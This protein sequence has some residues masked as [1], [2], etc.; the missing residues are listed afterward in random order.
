LNCQRI[1]ELMAGRAPDRLPWVPELNAGF[2]R[3][4]MGTARADA[5]VEFDQTD[6]KSGEEDYLGLEARCAEKIGADHLH[7]VQSVRVVRPNV[8]VET[9]EATGESLVHTPA[10]DLRQVKVYDEGSGT[11]Y[12]REHLVKG[13]EDF[14]AFRAM[15]ADEVYEADYENAQT[16]IDRSGMATVDVPATPL[17]HLLM[18]VMDVQPTLM[19][20]MERPDE[21]ADLMA[22]MH[23]RNLDYYR[24]AAAGPG[25]IFRPM[26]DTSAMLTGPRMYAEHSVAHL[27]DYAAVT[28]G[29]G[30]LFLPHMCGHVGGMLDVLVEIDLDGIEAITAPPLGDADVAEMRRRLPEA[31]LIGG[32]DPSQYA[33]AT[34]EQMRSHVQ[35]TLEAMRGDR[36]FMLGH[37]EIPLAARV[38]NVQIVAELVAATAEGFYD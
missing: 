32:V 26:E 5:P 9:D 15:I 10:G 2:V 8:R 30:K 3:R 11:V 13:P 19:A 17:M 33:T 16:E 4:M 21:M 23:E 37:E 38:E 31:W 28:H 35:G 1:A 12:T 20:M 27:N 24:V 14:E 25:E 18:W 22:F 6:R 36:R 34:P 7:R 29:A